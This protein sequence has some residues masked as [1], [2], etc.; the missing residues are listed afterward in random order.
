MNSAYGKTKSSLNI[1]NFTDI[2]TIEVIINIPTIDVFIKFF[3]N[4]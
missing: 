4:S 2:K 3:F 1:N